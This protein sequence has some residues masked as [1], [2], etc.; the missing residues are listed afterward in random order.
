M[1]S[2][3]DNFIY[4]VAINQNIDVC[5]YISFWN[6]N[7]SQWVFLLIVCKNIIYSLP[8]KKCLL[9]IYDKPHDPI[10]YTSKSSGS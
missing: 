8:R 5:I 1:I 7:I 9:Y 2:L 4:Y 6:W 3:Y 10:K